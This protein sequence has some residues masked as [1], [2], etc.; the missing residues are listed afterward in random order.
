[1]G[2]GVFLVSGDSSAKSMVKAFPAG[3]ATETVWVI[4]PK[5]A[6][7]PVSTMPS[8]PAGTAPF[9]EAVTMMEAA[10]FV[11]AMEILEELVLAEPTNAAAFRRLG[12]CHYNLMEFEEALTAYERAG[13]LR[14]NANEGYYIQRGEGFAHLHY[15]HQLWKQMDRERGSG[16]LESA[17]DTFTSAHE[18]YKKAL[19]ILT[20]CLNRAPDD[21]EAVYGR[22]MAAEGASRKLWSNAISHL[23]Y[24]Q[25]ERAHVFADNCIVV[26]N[27]GLESAQR[28]ASDPKF[29]GETGPYALMGGLYERKAT[30]YQRLGKTDL[31]LIE[32]NNAMGAQRAVLNIDKHNATALEKLEGC[33][34]YRLEWTSQTAATGGSM[35]YF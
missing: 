8:V 16:Q 12:E 24:G 19:E 13:E 30:L 25:I 6:R 28:R 1:M 34:K 7:S 3:L 2:G 35:G 20:L 23:N 10:H 4:V 9:D 29:Q 5:D 15:G 14:P 18:H 32:L 21:V 33:E 26:I 31:A 11:N 22:A 17:A 27:A